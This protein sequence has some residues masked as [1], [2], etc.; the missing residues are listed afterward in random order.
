MSEV[1]GRGRPLRTG[2]YLDD[3]TIGANTIEGCWRD[4]VEGMM[5]LLRAGMPLNAGKLK[6]L[7][8]EVPILG[9]TLAE[10]RFQL[11]KKALA[12]AFASTIPTNL[13]ELQQVLGRFNFAST[14]VPDY[15][16]L[17]KPLVK[18]TSPTS[19]GQWR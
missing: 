16:R 1:M 3:C 5:R 18:L 6:L 11:G 14:F 15:H 8:L 7:Q 10:E 2:I 9:V 19:G 4:T 17:A 12:K 13:T